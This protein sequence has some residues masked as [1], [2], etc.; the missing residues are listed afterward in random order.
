MAE[1]TKRSAGARERT[2]AALVLTLMPVLLGRLSAHWIEIPGPE[3]LP[4]RFGHASAYVPLNDCIYMLGGTQF[5]IAGSELDICQQYDPNTCIWTTMA[6][7]PGRRT[8]IAGAYVRGRIYICCG[9]TGSGVPNDNCWEY[10]ALA[11]TWATRLPAPVAQLAYMSGVWRDSLIYVM[12]GYG[13]GAGSE[14]VQ[15]YSPATNT[16]SIGTSMPRCGDMGGAVVVGDTIYVTNAYDRNQGALWSEILRGA[17]NPANPTEIAWFWGPRLPE[18]SSSHS[19][20]SLGGKVYW[21]GIVRGRQPD[22]WAMKGW[23]YDPATGGIDTIGSLLLGPAFLS[24]QFAVA[25]EPAG[26]LYQ[27]AGGPDWA[28][29]RLQ[30]NQSGIA[31][32]E[33]RAGAA[34]LRVQTMSGRTVTAVY[35]LDQ[36]CCVSL[37][38]YNLSGRVVRALV[39]GRMAAGRHTVLWDGRD[40]IGRPAGSGVYFCRLTADRCGDVAKLVLTR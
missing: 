27:I 35:E 18:P 3:S 11:D 17:I 28:Y 19:T 12:G 36:S 40:D 31:G 7:M 29:H 4:N 32:A 5:G 37:A 13:T 16:W 15:V 34:R 1:A 30:L 8:R 22:T 38:A 23:V 26:E 25:R 20:T 33:P 6:P 14:T 2:A 9:M 10:D 39:S 24:G 21:L